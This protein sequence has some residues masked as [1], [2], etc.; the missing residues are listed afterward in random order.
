MKLLLIAL[1]T[2]AFAQ[3]APK[4]EPLWADGAPGALGT[5]DVDK[6]T[7]AA[8]PVPQGRGVGTAVIVCPGGGYAHPSMDK[9]SDQ[10][11]PWLNSLGVTAFFLK[12]R[13]GPQYH[14]PIAICD[15]HRAHRPPGAQTAH[16]PA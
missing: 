12:Y 11:A 15:A 16:H 6:P 2:V 3:Q 10:F 7:L 14:H 8:Y 4:P 9:E 1:A 5:E 13:L